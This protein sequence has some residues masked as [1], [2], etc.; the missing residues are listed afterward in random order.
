MFFPWKSLAVAAA[1]LV[2]PIQAYWEYMTSGDL[3]KSGFDNDGIMYTRE[4]VYLYLSRVDEEKRHGLF[5]A[6]GATDRD[7]FDAI[8]EFQE[9]ELRLAGNA[10]QFQDVFDFENDFQKTMGLDYN[11]RD[12][13]WWRAVNRISKGIILR[14]TLIRLLYSNNGCCM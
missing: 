7:D 8:A 12:H 14:E 6:G 11:N 9:S 10:V 5:W 4:A 1:L 13:R 2:L 3:E